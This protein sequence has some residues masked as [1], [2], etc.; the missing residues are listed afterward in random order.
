MYTQM[1]FQKYIAQLKNNV[2]TLKVTFTLCS[3]PARTKKS[4]KPAWGKT[5]LNWNL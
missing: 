4:W 1:C 3:K 2:S 5:Q